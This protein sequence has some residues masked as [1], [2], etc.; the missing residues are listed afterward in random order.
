[1]KIR[2]TL[3]AQHLEVGY[4]RGN[5]SALEVD[6][7]SGFLSPGGP[8]SMDWMMEG[9]DSSDC[10]MLDF[11][12][13]SGGPACLLVSRFGAHRVVGIDVGAY[14]V[15]LAC[16]AAEQ[17]RLSDKISFQQ[18]AGNQLP[19]GTDSL[20]AV[21]S[22]DVIV[23][24]EKKRDLFAELFR[25]LRP[26]GRLIISDHLIPEDQRELNAIHKCWGSVQMTAFPVTVGETEKLLGACGFVDV[27]SVD[28]TQLYLEATSSGLQS[29]DERSAKISEYLDKEAAA[30]WLQY[31]D[32]YMGLVAQGAIL[33]VHS[34][35]VKPN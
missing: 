3:A 9:A 25:I 32:D 5:I 11:G 14:Q 23:H 22:K 20:D 24:V 35:G 16:K 12:C 6:L 31:M 27:R 21:F 33:F 30:D 34:Y 29:R 2:L 10:T 7:G 18:V 15:E 19:F 26:G 13:G 8:A 1:M 17:Q 28:R 4:N